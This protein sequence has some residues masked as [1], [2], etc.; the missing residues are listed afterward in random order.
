MHI[1]S[2]QMVV[3]WFSALDSLI[4]QRLKFQVQDDVILIKPF[5][6]VVIRY[7]VVLFNRL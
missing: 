4:L 5:Y 2:L 6:R 1:V 3:Y 7:L